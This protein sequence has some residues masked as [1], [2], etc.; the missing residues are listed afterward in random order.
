[1][2]LDVWKRIQEVFDAVIDLPPEQRPQALAIH[3]ANDASLRRR[4]ESLLLC[5][6]D[7]LLQDIV[8]GAF[9]SATQLPDPALIGDYKIVRR[10]AEG[11]MGVIYEAEQLSPQRKVAIKVMRSG[12]LASD[13]EKRLFEREAEALGRL[14]HGGIATIFE[15]GITPSGQ[16]YLVMEFVEGE[17]LA[18]HITAEG[19]PKSFRR[20]DLKSRIQLFLEICDA[21]TYAHQHGVI[22]RDLK[23]SNLMVSGNRIKV[24]DFGLARI[25]DEVENTR[26]ETGIVQGSLRYMSPEQARGEASRIDVRSDIYSLGVILYELISGLHPYLD[27]TD[28]LGAVQQICETPVRPLRAISRPVAADLETILDKAMAKDPGQRYDSVS[29][30]AGDLRRYLANEPILARPASL[31]YQLGKLIARNKLAAASLALVTLLILAFGIVSFTQ[32]LRIRQERDRANQEAETARQVSD[33]LVTL[34]RETNPV[35]T[36]GVLTAKDLLLAG[37]KR[38]NEQL[39]NTPELRARLLDNIGSAFNTVGPMDQ[40]IQSFEESIQIRGKDHPDAARSWSGLSDSYYNQGKYQESVAASRRALAIRRNSLQPDAPEITASMN[41][42]ALSLAAAGNLEEAARLYAEIE[43]LD[44]KYARETTH[45]AALRLSSYGSALRRLGRYEESIEKLKLAETRLTTLPR[46]GPRLRLWNDLGLALNAA[47][48]FAE[49]EATFR[50]AVTATSKVFGPDH[51]NVGILELNLTFSLLGQKKW[52]EAEANW[53]RFYAI[54]DNR[55][56]AKH[57]TWADVWSARA[58]LEEG[59]QRIA[60][61]LSFW[62]RALAH[63][64]A[65][66]GPE[67]HATHRT[68]LLRAITLIHAGKPGPARIQI[69]SILAKQTTSSANQ[70][71]AR[72][73]LEEAKSAV[74]EHAGGNG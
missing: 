46:Q 14:V 23:P 72:K 1:V 33:F 56:P 21:I 73:A 30:F 74:P 50:K 57:P 4:V 20:V 63:S 39:K 42:L 24:L 3:C 32:A 65:T 7:G 18:A 31:S 66:L 59:H 45:E 8:Q 64:Q 16:P 36:N 6:K 69:E 53:K 26:T 15:S 40:A 13:R 11:G 5:E 43:A 35:E 54:F 67:H 41:G 10:L 48:R 61:A 51:L 17:T 71:L 58:Q 49:A 19:P 2:N 62:D 27:R 38:V 44:R 28:L 52:N 34:F 55:L 29:A 68:A 22:H 60:A 47:D 25:E 70:Q 37:R 12:Q 9:H